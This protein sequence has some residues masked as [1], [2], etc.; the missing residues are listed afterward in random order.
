MLLIPT[1]SRMDKLKS[2]ELISVSQ[3]T[4]LYLPTE[5]TVQES[6]D[7]WTEMRWYLR[8][9]LSRER[10]GKYEWHVAQQRVKFKHKNANYVTNA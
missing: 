10:I 2:C 3:S 5:N 6:T 4:S 7:G 1:F 9:K 8:F